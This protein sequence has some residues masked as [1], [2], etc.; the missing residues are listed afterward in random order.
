MSTP[1][2]K[3]TTMTLSEPTPDTESLLL[4]RL[5]SS[6]TVEDHFRWL[7]FVVGFYR[8]VNKTDQAVELLEQ[9]I[10]R[11][12]D[13]E[14]SSHCYLALGQIATDEGRHDAALEYF[15]KAL[16]LEPKK[17]TVAYVLHNNIGYSLN[18]LGRFI[19][20][21]R[22]C[23]TAID[24]DSTR[25]SGYRNLGV[26]LHGRNRV[27]EAAWA[28]AESI[29]VDSTDDRAR[30][31]LEKILALHPN[32]AVQCPWIVQVL[33]FHPVEQTSSLLI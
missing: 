6:T 8:G 31:L 2:K 18:A 32:L 5:K 10:K 7:L 20:A 21:E 11:S 29:K 14:Q 25:G 16:N 22:H 3:D 17:R 12:D 30:A 27:V 33:Y 9:F 26:S 19:D 4:A 23:R 15:T 28:L 13:A 1:E 24:I